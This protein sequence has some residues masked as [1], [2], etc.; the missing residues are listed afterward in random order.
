[1]SGTLTDSEINMIGLWRELN[2][3]GQ[4]T[5]EAMIRGLALQDIYKIIPSDLVAKKE[6]CTEDCTSTMKCIDLIK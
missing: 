6:A 4:E 1:M 5:A 3:E 2:E